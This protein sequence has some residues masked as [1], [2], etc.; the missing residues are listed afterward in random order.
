MTNFS[1]NDFYI[2]INNRLCILVF[3]NNNN[4]NNF[5]LLVTPSLIDLTN[6]Y[7]FYIITCLR[8][9][10]TRLQNILIR[11]ILHLNFNCTN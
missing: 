2:V 4:N 10:T 11:L 7:I 6:S 1:E 8:H 5:I 3:N 9:N